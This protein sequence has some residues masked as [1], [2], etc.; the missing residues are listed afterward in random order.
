NSGLGSSSTSFIF[1]TF[2][3]FRAKLAA[4]A[5]TADDTLAM[6]NLAAGP[7]NPASGSANIAL[8]TANA[9]ALGYSI[10]AGADSSINLNTSICNL[11]HGTNTNGGFYD[12]YAVACHEIDEALGTVSLVG[13]PFGNSRPSSAD[14]FRYNAGAHSWDTSTTHAAFFSIDGTNNIVEYNQLGRSGGDWGDWRTHSP[15]QVQDWAGSPG[16]T[17]DMGASETRLLD[18]VGY[19]YINPVPEPAT[20]LALGLGAVALIRRRKK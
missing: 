8:S 13:D 2:A 6:A 14:M 15:A 16:V 3:N 7:N 12:L 4:D 9:K 17:V 5:S 1:D 10:G 18:V 19:N 20:V 11:V